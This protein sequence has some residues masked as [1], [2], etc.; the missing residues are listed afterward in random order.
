MPRWQ[1]WRFW[2]FWSVWQCCR[3]NIDD[4]SLLPLLGY[5]ARNCSQ[6]TFSDSG[7]Q[8]R[9]VTDSHQLPCESGR[10]P[11]GFLERNPHVVNGRYHLFLSFWPSR[12]LFTYLL[13]ALGK[14]L[15]KLIEPRNIVK[16]P[17]HGL[18]QSF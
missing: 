12:C 17:L 2:D 16:K 15:L 4:F 3:V 9:T 8:T 14:L 10:L 1:I 5:T 11:G 13:G 18:S 6:G 7:C